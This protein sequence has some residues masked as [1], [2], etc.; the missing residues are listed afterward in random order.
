MY[1]TY[2]P[3][4]IRKTGKVVGPGWL[5]SRPDLRDYTE[6]SKEI[7]SK[8]LKLGLSSAGKLKKGLPKKWI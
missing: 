5:P 8:S 6:N 7:K 2:K 1:A 3:V 4:K